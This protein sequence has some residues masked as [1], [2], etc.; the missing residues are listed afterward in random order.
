MSRIPLT[1][2]A[3]STWLDH[4]HAGDWVLDATAGNGGDTAFLARRVG[5]QGRVFAIDIQESALRATADRLQREV[6]LARVTLVQGDHARLLE[7]LPCGVRGRLRLV[8]FNLGYLPGGDHHCTTLPDSTRLALQASLL[9]LAD[10]G[11]LSVMA[12]RG[13]PGGLEEADVVQSFMDHLPRPWVCLQH[14]ATGSHANPGPVWWLVGRKPEPASPAHEDPADQLPPRGRLS[15]RKDTDPE[16]AAG[17]PD[18]DQREER[19]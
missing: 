2:I 8:C 17:C 13:H 10:E 11:T 18:G 9:L 12:Y 1:E 15:L 6:L 7:L 14:L 19:A 4:V 3:Q 16:D 5:P